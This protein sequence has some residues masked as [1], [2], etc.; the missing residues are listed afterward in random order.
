MGTK[1]GPGWDQVRIDRIL[2]VQMTSEHD[3]FT[4]M[5]LVGRSNRTKFREVVLAPL[6]AFD[7]V[8][9]TIPNK[10]NSSKQRYRL[11]E[12]GRTVRDAVEG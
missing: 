12:L 10:P 1:W 11:T 2:V 4:L 8:A 3:I 5:T 6:L 7:L 9:M